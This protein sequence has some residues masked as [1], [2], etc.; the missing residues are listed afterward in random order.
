MS[1]TTVHRLPARRVAPSALGL[2]QA[3][4]LGLAEAA[5]ESIPAGRYVAAHLAALRAAAALLATREP[6]SA[7]RRGRPRSVWV[8]LPEA[9]PAL[10]E[11]A[12]FF[13]AGAD[14]RAAAEAG[15][16][17]AVTAGEAGELLRDAEIF[18]SLVEDTL[19]VPG[20]PTLPIADF[21]AS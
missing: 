5:E 9:D 15:L 20:R 10:S 13:A 18:V 16:P 2:L 19:G 21:R 12:A 17:R 8:L 3:A 6:G 7:G 4:R 11:W 1:N 14:K